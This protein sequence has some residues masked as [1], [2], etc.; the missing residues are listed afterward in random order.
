[1]AS[2]HFFSASIVV[3]A[4]LLRVDQA[5]AVP[6]NKQYRDFSFACPTGSALRQLSSTWSGDG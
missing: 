2:K 4:L 6:A 3:L 5:L 1:M